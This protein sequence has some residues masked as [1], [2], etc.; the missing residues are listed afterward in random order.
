MNE[1]IEIILSSDKE[2]DKTP[3]YLDGVEL[4]QSF[5]IEKAM[6]NKT[7]SPE[8]VEESA[9][10][11]FIPRSN[12][13]HL[14]DKETLSKMGAQVIEGYETDWSSMQE[15]RDFVDK[16]QELVKQEKEGRST[17]WQGASNFKTPMIMQACLKLSDRA[18]MEIFRQADIVKTKVIGKDE[19]E[20]KSK[21]ADRVATYSNYQINTDMPEWGDEHEKLIYDLPYP[22]TIFKKTFYDSRLGRPDSVMVRHPNFAVNQATTSLERLRRFSEIFSLS[23]NEIYERQEQGIWREVEL[24]SDE[25]TEA[26][27]SDSTIEEQTLDDGFNQF[28]EQ[29]GFYDLDGDGY[30]EPYIM[31]VHRSSQKVVRVIPRFDLENVFVKDEKNFRA[32]RL[33]DAEDLTDFEVVRIKPNNNI[34]KYGFITDPQG[35]FLNVGFSYL[36]GALSASINSTTNQL[37]DAGTLANLASSTGYLAKGFRAKMG[38]SMFKPGEMKETNLNAQDLQTGIRMSTVSQPSPTLFSLMQFMIAAGQ[39]LSASADLSTSLGANAPATTTLALVQEQQQFSG[40]IIIK[41][42]RSMTAEFKKIFELNSKY[43]DPLEYQR[44]LDDPQANFEKDF[45]LAGMDIGPAANPEISSRLQRIQLAEVKMARLN[46]IVAAGGDPRPVVIDF[47]VMIGETDVDKIFPEQ[48]P[49]EVLQSLI[50]KNPQLAEMIGGEQQRAQLLMQAEQESIQ[51]QRNLTLAEEARKDAEEERKDAKTAMELNKARSEIA[52]NEAST[53][54]TLEE[55]ET[56]NLQNDVTTY[57]TAVQLNQP[58]GAINEPSR[59]PRVE[60]TPPNQFNP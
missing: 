26:M 1:E 37:V 22:G 52:K 49:E 7:I 2:S 60:T 3:E 31:T 36:L 44:V 25:Q 13:T 5:F 58:T 54:K 47:L 41:L 56:E 38:G 59:L 39:E 10:S 8:G 17:P 55:A 50:A 19:D 46:E 12:I 23:A 28:I 29:Q 15:W 6:I 57:T 16:G 4:L 48:S 27:V 43:I 53:I 18:F 30:Q 35:G 34:T 14:I 9:R 11:I 21:R 51:M 40:V 33:S 42:Y 24:K 45:N 20:E 32:V